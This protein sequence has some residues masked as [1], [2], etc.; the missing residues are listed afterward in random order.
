MFRRNTIWKVILVAGKHYE[1]T[2]GLFLPSFFNYWYKT[3]IYS[4]T[5]D[6]IH[7]NKHITC[8][9]VEIWA[10]MPQS[11]TVLMIFQLIIKKKINKSLLMQAQATF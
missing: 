8:A 5:Y 9:M 10:S 1:I 11:S 4:Y 7:F 6:K 3:I 2:N